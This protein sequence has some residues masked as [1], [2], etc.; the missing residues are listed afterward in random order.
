MKIASAVT[1]GGILMVALCLPLGAENA[2]AQMKQ[3]A[4]PEA[5]RRQQL[6]QRFRVRVGQLV[7]QRLQ[8]NDAQVTR[9]ESVNRQFEQQ[10]LGLTGRERALRRELRQQLAPGGAAN[11]ARVAELLDQ[12][13]RLQRQRLDVVDAEQR[14]LAKFLNPVQRARYFGLQNELRKRMQE[15]RGP[16]A[17]ANPNARRLARPNRLRGLN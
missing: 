7:R 14:E 15:L 11:E 3:P 4:Q 9:L 16:A 8:L 2:S 10:R 5:A 13:I 1:C 17:P 12:T 6:E